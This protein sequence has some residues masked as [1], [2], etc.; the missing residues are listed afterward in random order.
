MAYLILGASLLVGLGLIGRWLLN[1]EPKDIMRALRW[2]AVIAGLGLALFL[3]FRG[4]LD[5]ALYAGGVILPLLLRWGR[6]FKA[7]KNTAKAAR[8][9]T[10]GQSSNVRAGFVA[11][12]LDHDS[13]EMDG[14]ILEGSYS[15]RFLS[16]LS[17]QEFLDLL[18]QAEADEQSYQLLI[19]WAEKMHGP[20]WN[21]GAEASSAPRSDAGGAMTRAQAYEI[22][23]LSEGASAED[24]KA[25]HKRLMMANHPDRGGSEWLASRI[26]QAKDLLLK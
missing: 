13:G 5:W 9:P 2:G 16:D 8:G 23:G 10:P 26:N 3:L 19:A 18:N 20:D 17:Q 14:E 6:V 21:D 1:A 24:I 22:L 7:L 12:T 4:R 25:A 11:M 15:G